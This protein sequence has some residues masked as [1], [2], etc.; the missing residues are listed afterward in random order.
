[1]EPETITACFTAGVAFLGIGMSA[2]FAHQANKH[3]QKSA[4]SAMAILGTE[5]LREQVQIYKA[6]HTAFVYLGKKQRYIPKILGGAVDVQLPITL[7]TSIYIQFLTALVSHDKFFQTY[8][9]NDPD[10]QTN[11]TSLYMAFAHSGIVNFPNDG[12]LAVINY[13]VLTQ[14]VLDN[15]EL[16]LNDMNSVLTDNLV[17]Q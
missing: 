12:D 15:L 14:E 17:H 13:D 11:A 1:M 2:W 10:L 8:L 5:K 4:E 6:I 3:A 16:L 9:N 7:P